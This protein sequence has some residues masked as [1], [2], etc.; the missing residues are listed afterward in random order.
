MRHLL[1]QKY[2]IVPSFLT[3]ISPVEFGKFF[4]QNEHLKDLGVVYYAPVL[5]DFFRFSFCFSQHQDVI[6][7]DWSFHV[8]CNDSTLVAAFEYAHAYLNDFS[9]DA[10]AADYLSNFGWNESFF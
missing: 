3:W 8:S 4:P 10:G 9:C 2:R 6:K 7:S 5:P 1:E